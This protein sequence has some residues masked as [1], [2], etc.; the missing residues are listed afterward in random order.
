MHVALQLPKP[1][2]SR[3]EYVLV[4]DV[5]NLTDDSDFFSV[6]E[7]TERLCSANF[8]DLAHALGKN[9]GSDWYFLT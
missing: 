7:Y 3:F 2:V 1:K 8:Y 4:K 5:K 9:T 6:Q